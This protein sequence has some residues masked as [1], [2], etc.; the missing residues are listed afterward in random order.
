LKELRIDFNVENTVIVDV[1]DF[2]ETIRIIIIYWSPGQTRNLEELV[3][4]H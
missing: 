3:I 1:D 2:C 4:Y